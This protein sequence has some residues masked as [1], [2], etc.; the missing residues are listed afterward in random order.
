M[1][2]GVSV[3]KTRKR[4]S[5]VATVTGAATIIMLAI[6]FVTNDFSGLY[7]TPS[8]IVQDNTMSA[9]EPIRSDDESEQNNNNDDGSGGESGVIG[10]E[11]NNDDLNDNVNDN[12]SYP[13]HDLPCLDPNCPI[14]HG[15]DNHEIPCNDPN[16]PICN[17]KTPCDDPDCPICNG[18]SDDKPPVDIPMDIINFK[19]NSNE[20]ANKENTMEAL[21]TY[22]DSFERYFELYPDGKIYLIG[23]IAKTASWYLTETELSEERAEAVRKSLIDLGIDEDR[24]IAIG[25]GISDPWRNDEWSEGYFNEA[26]AK[27]NRRVWIVPDEYEKQVKLILSIDEKIDA[28][29]K[30]N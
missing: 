22:I 7:S 10:D 24:L 14:H 25:I 19:P 20:F 29:K 15:G 6:A 23:C 2:T 18:E 9:L 5:T 1:N 4:L 30:S 21:S 16:C 28:L 11:D 26:V 12:E 17:H 8:F 27:T 13:D 3:S